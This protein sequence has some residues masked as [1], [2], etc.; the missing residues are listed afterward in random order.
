MQLRDVDYERYRKFYSFRQNIGSAIK[1]M[2]G[3]KPIDEVEVDTSTVINFEN[4][5]NKIRFFSE[6]VPNNP[7]KI[8]KILGRGDNPDKNA[9]K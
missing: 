9:K 1:V 6:L 3:R 5:L 4:N 7:D 2:K 8:L